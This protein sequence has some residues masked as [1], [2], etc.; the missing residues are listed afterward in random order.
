[1]KSIDAPIALPGGS[2]GRYHDDFQTATFLWAPGVA[3]V[4]TTKTLR[5]TWWSLNQFSKGLS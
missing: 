1:M 4:V 5:R 3:E 2:R